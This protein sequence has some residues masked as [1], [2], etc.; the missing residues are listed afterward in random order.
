MLLGFG[1]RPV[2]GLQASHFLPLL[3]VLLLVFVVVI[4]VVAFVVFV[5]VRGVGTRTNIAIGG[6]MSLLPP[7]KV[8]RGYLMYPPSRDTGETVFRYLRTYL[9]VFNLRLL[10]QN[11]ISEP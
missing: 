6:G 7:K 1:I 3:L 5:L 4:L 2:F 10:R 11:P 8:C 9:I